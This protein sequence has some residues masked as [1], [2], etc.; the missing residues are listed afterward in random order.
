M[1]GERCQV[2][3]GRA[4]E[5]LLGLW[6]SATQG[7]TER[8][9]TAAPGQAPSAFLPGRGVSR[10]GLLPTWRKV[11]NVSSFSSGTLAL[12]CL[13]WWLS[14][15]P[16]LVPRPQ[17]RAGGWSGPDPGPELRGACLHRPRRPHL[18][19]RL[20]GLGFRPQATV[21][22][23]S[24]R[25]CLL[26]GPGGSP[27]LSLS[28]EAVDGPRGS[29]QELPAWAPPSMTTQRR[30]VGRSRR[31]SRG[32]G[33]EARALPANTQQTR[34][35]ATVGRP[36]RQAQVR[37]GWAFLRVGFCQVSK[38]LRARL[39]TGEGVLGSG[40]QVQTQETPGPR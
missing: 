33:T 29:R 24:V 8:E 28:R 2:T 16:P 6:L 38:S 4:R 36:S 26:R 22:S 10:T 27:V 32:H 37:E 30:G 35:Q 40:Q 25:G 21:C 3:E 15:R 34:S 7:G 19:P 13:R 18:R 11:L 1:D 12:V 14:G 9:A 39:L 17:P 20:L 5:Q 23:P 31:A